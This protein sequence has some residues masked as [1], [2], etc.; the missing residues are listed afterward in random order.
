MLDDGSV[1]SVDNIGTVVTLEDAGMNEEYVLLAE[2]AEPY[3]LNLRSPQCRISPT[4]TAKQDDIIRRITF[5]TMNI[6]ESAFKCEPGLRIAYIP[7]DIVGLD[8]DSKDRDD[9]TALTGFMEL[10]K[11][12]RIS[13]TWLRTSR[14]MWPT[15]QCQP[16]LF[17]TIISVLQV[18]FT[19]LE[20]AVGIKLQS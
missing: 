3:Q 8:L 17:A 15:D 7:I 14:I 16:V 5:S 1:L 12:L 4:L 13:K 19:A 18:I 6:S 9:P 10:T 11:T 20:A 2:N